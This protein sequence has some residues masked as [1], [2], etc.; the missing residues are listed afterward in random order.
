MIRIQIRISN[1]AL[2]QQCC[3]GVC[4]SVESE[5]SVVLT[6]MRRGNLWSSNTHQDAN[7]E[8]LIKVCQQNSSYLLM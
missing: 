8:N 6:A 5:I 1:T 4:V 2:D 3:D 7:T